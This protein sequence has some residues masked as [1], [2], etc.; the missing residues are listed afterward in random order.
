MEKT[1]P[2]AQACAEYVLLARPDYAI[3]TVVQQEKG[4][5]LHNYGQ[6]GAVKTKQ[7]IVVGKFFAT[8]PM[9][10]TV[11]AWLQRICSVQ[12]SFIVM[13]NNYSGFPAHTIYMRVQNQ[14]PFLAL[15]KQLKQ[16]D[17]YVLGNTGY[18][19][20]WATQP[21]LAIASHLPEDV[22]ANAL[23]DYAR[24]EFTGSFVVNEL[25]L[26]R[27][28]SQYTSGKTIA[29]LGLRPE[30]APLYFHQQLQLF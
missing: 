23:K 16:I 19:V 24:K 14:Q 3:E 7:H 18:P 15:A 28:A 17:S 12:Q 2:I 9:E 13:L 22:Y 4:E 8:E 10:Q 5:F 21:H 29:V 6:H 20:V 1:P 11:I 30:V 25:I 26:K 27:C